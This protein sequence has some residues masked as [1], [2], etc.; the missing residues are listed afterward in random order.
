MCPSTEGVNTRHP[1]SGVSAALVSVST[2]HRRHY[3]RL[4][5]LLLLATDA[6][7]SPSRPSHTLHHPPM[8]WPE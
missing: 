4:V 8:A 5:H 1:V 3:S 2:L 6:A 7:A